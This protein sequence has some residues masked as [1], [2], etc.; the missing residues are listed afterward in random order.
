MKIHPKRSF[1]F[2]L[3][4]FLIISMVHPLSALNNQEKQLSSILNE[5]YDSFAKKDMDSYLSLQAKS[6]D[7][8][9]IE[10]EWESMDVL[11][12]KLSR[13]ELDVYKNIALAD[14]YL[15]MRLGI[16]EN[17]V[18]FE[19]PMRAIMV[20]KDGQWK[21]LVVN[22]KK[23]M[24][25]TLSR[26]RIESFREEKNL[27]AKE[28]VDPILD[29]DPEKEQKVLPGPCGD[30]VCELGESCYMDCSMYRSSCGDG[31]CEEGEDCFYDCGE[32]KK[33]DLTSSGSC[34]YD[35]SFE[36]LT[37]IDLRSAE[38]P[39]WIMKSLTNDL[40]IRLSVDNKNYFFRVENGSIRP[41]PVSEDYNYQ[42]TTDSC[43]LASIETGSITFQEAYDSKK[44][45]IE[46][47]DFNSKAKSFITNLFLKILSLFQDKPMKIIIE[48]ESGKL[49]NPGRFS[50]VGPTSRG[51]GELYLGEGDSKAIY[52]FNSSIRG[53]AYVY[54]RTSD[55]GKHE[56]GSRDAEFL[57]EG[58]KLDYKHKSHDVAN[59][60]E[61]EYLGNLN[62]SKGPITLTI[63]KPKQTSAAFIL[64]KI[65]ITNIDEPPT[66]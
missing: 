43:T 58:F 51:P 1:L 57:F 13:L 5:Y 19:E 3:S 25:E 50:F 60:W 29:D 38:I 6:A 53:Q 9:I 10:K 27:S 18:S 40:M 39:S 54:I 21:I 49:V 8:N 36:E 31:V 7:R 4:T 14:Y 63:T 66:N 55:D 12:Y 23:L 47:N 24:D 2:L 62:L 16:G 45:V 35:D 52:H 32:P 42:V 59:T 37:N 41:L 56:D 46:G 11:Y 28:D 30:G 20:F 22:Q 33:I 15:D 64:D 48:G 17:I 34:D 61:W 44:I 26:L 65:L